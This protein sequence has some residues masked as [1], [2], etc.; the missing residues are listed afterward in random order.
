MDTTRKLGVVATVA[1]SLVTVA[2]P[3]FVGSDHSHR[4]AVPAAAAVQVAASGWTTDMRVT[5]TGGCTFYPSLYR[6]SR[7][8]TAGSWH[9][10]QNHWVGWRYRVNKTWT[11]VLDHHHRIKGKPRW[12]FVETSCLTGNTY[13][14]GSKDG[15]GKVRNLWGKGSHG[16]RHIQFGT[17]RRR[18]AHTLGTRTIRSTYTTMRDKPRAFVTANLFHANRFKITNQCTSRSAHAWIY[19]L[20]LQSRRWGWLPSSTLRG[21]PCL[22]MR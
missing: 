10:P 17:T 15:H 3:A 12:A 18:G 1:A 14:P 16:W 8:L 22:H 7:R 2:A 11:L 20:D 9:E 6:T 13:P 21:N 5:R 4:P 19:G